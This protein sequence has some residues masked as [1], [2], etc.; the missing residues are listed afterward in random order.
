M[1]FESE[2]L[3]TVAIYIIMVAAGELCFIVR[4]RALIFGMCVLY[5]KTFSTEP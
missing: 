3:Y 2:G 5:D 4:D 1:T